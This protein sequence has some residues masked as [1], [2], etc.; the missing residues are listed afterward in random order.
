MKIITR[1]LP[2]AGG[3][4]RSAA[5]AGAF[6]LVELLV[7]IAI[8]AVLAG[9]SLV[10]V[11]QVKKT[12]WKSTATAEL[13]QIE[14]ALEAYKAQYGV[15]PPSNA[16]PTG[17]YTSPVTNSLLPQLYYEL[18]GVTNQNG[19]TYVTLDG[20]AS[21]AVTDVQKAFG[22]AGFLN[23]SKGGVEDATA[24]RNFL[25][26]LR[27][28]QIGTASDN[29]VAITNILTS[30]RGPDSTYM[31]LGVLDANPFRYVYPGVNNP[32]SYDLWVQ[33]SMSGKT[34]LICNWTK[35][36]AINNPLP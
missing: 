24:A 29:G 35:A 23:C 5:G 31:P 20:S 7:V 19:T 15:Y 2:V 10:V 8:M 4:A 25:L 36:V 12:Q 1:K 26:G 32:G 11:G 18:S 9:L 21:I 3:R 27:K 6:T 22:V 28:G 14:S 30:V 17:T 16:N 33:L 34:Y 13:N